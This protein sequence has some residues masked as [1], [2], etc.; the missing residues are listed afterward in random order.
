MIDIQEGWIRLSLIL[1]LTFII[2]F[3]V[4]LWIK[5]YFLVPYKKLHIL[6]F[7]FEKI[8]FV[9]VLFLIIL[10]PLNISLEK[11][12][13]EQKQK[14]L[15]I[16]ILF[17]VSLSMVV[18][19]MQPSRI[20]VARNALKWLVQNLEWNNIWIIIY[21]WIPFNW[22][23]FSNQTDAIISKVQKMNLS[24]FPP[25][26]NFVWT[27]IWDSIY[28]WLDNLIR[29]Y[30]NDRSN[31]A[32]IL[33]TDWD[34]NKWSD[35]FQAAEYANSLSIPIYWV[36]IWRTDQVVGRDSFNNPVVAKFNFEVLQKLVKKTGWKAYHVVDESQFEKVF[37]QII[38][39]IKAKESISIKYKS[40]SL[41]RY[42][43]M[44]IPFLISI[45]LFIRIYV[46]RR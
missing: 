2:V 6:R 12:E 11:K 20:K 14:N 42:L 15:N 35:P 33:L 13:I 8:I 39:D 27:A 28:L 19:D 9:S 21:S 29:F 16:Q 46:L 31:Q 30:W 26:R 22:I 18:D 44:I 41:N 36:W 37:Q 24:E 32:L 7:L 23:P 25:T 34:S 4:S 38:S 10:L 43:Y 3:F 17:D 40:V 45:L 1:L 5:P